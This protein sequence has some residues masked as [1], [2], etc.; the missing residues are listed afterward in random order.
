M[1]IEYIKDID[2]SKY[3]FTHNNCIIE[4]RSNTLSSVRSEITI[5]GETLTL[6][7]SPDGIYYFNFKDYV[8]SL[9]NSNNYTDDLLT[10]LS[11]TYLY[12]WTPRVFLSLDI[13]VNVLLT[14]DDVE[15][16]LRTY[17]FYLSAAN[18]LILTLKK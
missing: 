12:D 8:T 13:D 11:V 3:I 6:Y 5:N 18:L 9:I 14:N 2:V 4:Y 17:N 7:P 15:S 1:A 16:D 10:D